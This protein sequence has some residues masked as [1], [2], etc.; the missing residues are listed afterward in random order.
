VV[1]AIRRVEYD[2]KPLSGRFVRPF[3]GNRCTRGAL[4]LAIL[5]CFGL[6][7]G[8]IKYMSDAQFK[9]QMV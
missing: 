4:P 9:Y 2:V 5:R 6:E 7:R 1:G 3:C 8:I